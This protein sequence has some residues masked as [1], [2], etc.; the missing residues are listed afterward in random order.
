L[1]HPRKSSSDL[2]ARPDRLDGPYE[3]HWL[4][5][6]WDE[7]LRMR[8]RVGELGAGAVAVDGRRPSPARDGRLLARP[9]PGVSPTFHVLDT[10]H[11]KAI[12]R[13]PARST[14]SRRFR[15]LVQVGGTLET[16]RTFD[17]FWERGAGAASFVAIPDPGSALEA[18][19]V[20]GAVASPGEPT[21][22]GRYSALSPFGLVPAALMG[23]DVARLLDRAEETLNA[24]RVADGNPAS[25]SGLRS[26]RLAG[27]PRQ[28]RLPAEPHGSVCGSSSCS[29]SRPARRARARA[30]ARRVARRPDRQAREVELDDPY[31][32]GSEFFRW[33]FATAVAG[34]ILEINPFDQPNVQ[35]AKDRTSQILSGQGPGTSEPSGDG[36][37]RAG[38]ARRL[39]RDPGVRRP[40]RG[41]APTAP[42]EGWPRGDRLLSSPFGSGRATSTRTGQLHKGER[43]SA[44]SSRSWTTPGRAAIP[45]QK[46]GFGRLIKA[47]AEGDYAALKERG[48]PVARIDWRRSHE[49]RNGRPR[50]DGREHGRAA[51]RARPHG[52]DLRAT[53]PERHGELAGRAR[54]QAPAAARSCWLMIPA[55]DP[56]E[57]AFQTLL[58]LL[59]DGDIDRRRRQL[60]LPRLAAP[61][62]RG[63]EE[64]RL[65]SSTRASPAGS[66]G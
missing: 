32:L 5:L 2:G 17:F 13:L 11:P 44:A 48:R 18:L 8:E 50:P 22:G 6:G 46:F 28:G 47:Q 39:R 51:A 14:S 63:G 26:A 64:G 20:R 58:G 65:R 60:E 1:I 9:M 49:P 62:G 61:R 19:R 35:E 7:P 40:R 37:A 30:R 34:A 10:T 29:R 54:H 33:E 3:A 12:R 16:R 57:T 25:R 24:C 27:G 43:R 4:G 56:T 23:V 53:N 52:G 66:G 59:E 21:I 31:D 36:A 45:G 15:R 41:G 55:G 42:R 38:A